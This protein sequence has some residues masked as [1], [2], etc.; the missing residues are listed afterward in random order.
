M[1]L[2]HQAGL[3]GQ[4]KQAVAIG[5]AAGQLGQGDH[6]IAIGNLA[7]QLFQHENSICINAR[8]NAI[9]KWQFRFT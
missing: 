3:S 7:G 8:F 4:G 6:A 9:N 5:V 2:V 1:L